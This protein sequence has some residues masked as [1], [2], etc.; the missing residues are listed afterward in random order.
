L[1]NEITTLSAALS[2][3]KMGFS[4]IPILPMDKKPAVRWE[5]YIKSLA[6]EDQLIKWFAGGDFNLAIVTGE[7]S[8]ITVID[9]DT[10]GAVQQIEKMLQNT[11]NIPIQRT[12]RGGK[13][14]IFS[15][16]KGFVSRRVA[17]GIDIKSNGGYIIVPPSSLANGKYYWESGKSLFNVPPPIMDINFENLLRA[18]GGNYA[19]NGLGGGRQKI[20][21]IPGNMF[22]GGQLDED[23]FSIA[24][25]LTK[26]GI[27]P[28]QTQKVLEILAGYGNQ[29]RS[30]RPPFTIEDVKAKVQSAL[31]RAERKEINISQ[32]V[33][34]WISVAPGIFE[35]K[36][37]ARELN[38]NDI[39][40]LKLIW[41]MLDK[42]IKEGIVE[43]SGNRRGSYRI[44]E[45]NFEEMDFDAAEGEVINV[46]WPLEVER[47]YRC[48]PGSVAVLAG[49]MGSGKTTFSLNYCLKNL[50]EHKVTYLSSELG[51]LELRDRIALFGYPR[52]VWKPATFKKVTSNFEDAIDPDGV[53]IVDYLELYDELWK[54]GLLI[55][56][57]NDRLKSGTAL[58]MLQ[59]P[60]GRAVAK[61]GE[62]TLE[63]P[64]LYLSMDQPFG[65]D[66]RIAVL[67]AHNW[68]DSSDNPKNKV[69]RFKIIKGSRIDATSDW[70]R[71]EI[72]W[73]DVG[74][75]R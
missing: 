35:I 47:L 50:K 1:E 70:E 15:Y 48:Y 30:G 52:D 12:P 26:G 65:E 8:G 42:M 67:K 75:K 49:V 60:H 9:T 43:K 46:S 45:G 40:N 29:N 66:H 6:S 14:Y 54:M 74:R 13:H 2:Y 17:D 20:P 57:I 5:T 58:I 10:Q 59:R 23:L 63:K 33:R 3:R 56:N 37:I 61:G 41:A 64:R 7:I 24:N 32:E 69:R 11:V 68:R 51:V 25:A 31:S 39:N 4:V 73:A 44:K 16:T 71:E 53:N 19:G 27:Y 18:L 55:K 36:D 72:D 21:T 28:E 34:D 62:A 22:M 38:L